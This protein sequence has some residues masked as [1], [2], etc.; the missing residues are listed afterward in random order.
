MFQ[1][2]ALLLGCKAGLSKHASVQFINSDIYRIKL[3]EKHTASA[4]PQQLV[5]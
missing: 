2:G 1:T 3:A 4:T 5:Y